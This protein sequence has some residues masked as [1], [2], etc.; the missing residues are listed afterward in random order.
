MPFLRERPQRLRQH[1]EPVHFERRLAGLGE[2]TTSLHPDEIAEIK[3]PKNLHRLRPEFLCLHVNL[4]ASRRVAQVE[5]VT[6]PH[7]AM[8]R[9]PAGRAERCAFGKF[10][11]QLGNRAA[12]RKALAKGGHTAGAQRFEFLAPQRDQFILF[13]HAGDRM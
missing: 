2:E 9:D 12:R 1:F 11:P 4:D 6:L 5:K 10:F 7:V 8:R 3:Q 13:L